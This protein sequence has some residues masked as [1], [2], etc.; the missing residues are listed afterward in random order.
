MKILLL[1][2]IASVC[3]LEKGDLA[4]ET[5]FANSQEVVSNNVSVE[6]VKLEEASWEAWKHRDGKFFQVF[7]SD[8]HVEVAFGGTIDK[9][10][11]VAGVGSGACEV[12]SYK[13]D[14]FKATLFDKDTA[15]L[16]YHAEQD[17]VCNGATVPSPVWATSIYVRRGGKWLNALYQQTQTSVK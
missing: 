4:Y 17:T 10:Q 7:L 3:C 12:K 16:T 2:V 5:I 14:R 15:V 6:L 8:D 13:V 1:L 11:V 9:A